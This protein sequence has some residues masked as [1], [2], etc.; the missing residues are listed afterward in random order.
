MKSFSLELLPHE[1]MY[2][3]MVRSR[4]SSAEP[5]TRT[6]LK[7]LVGNAH[8]Q[9]HSSFPC[10]I[11]HVAEESGR[12][13]TWLV[14]NHTIFPYFSSF[15]PPEIQ[16]QSRMGL[17]RGQVKELPSRL[18]L[19]ANRIYQPCILKYCPR[20][21]NNDLKSFGV[22]YWHVIHQ[23]PFIQFC[24]IHA[25]VLANE[26]VKRRT[27]ILPPQARCSKLNGPIASEKELL[28][29]SISQGLL[30]KGI[31]R[32]NLSRVTESYKAALQLSGF[33][34]PS[35]TIHQSDWAASLQTFWK[36]GLPSELSTS[37]F[38]DRAKLNFPRCVL[39]QP[40]ALHHPAKHILL[41]GQLFGSLNEFLRCYRDESFIF[42]QYVNDNLERK[43][44]VPNQKLRRLQKEL[45]QGKS[46]R[47]ASKNAQVSVGYAKSFALKNCFE[48][49]RRAQR[50]FAGERKLI[51][52]RLKE[53][54][55]TKGIA[56]EMQCSV[57]AVEQLLT[58]HPEIKQ[59]RVKLRFNNKRNKHRKAI[60]KFLDYSTAAKRND[61]KTS[62]GAAYTWCYKN[63]K[64]WLYKMLP[65]AIPREE[66]Y[67]GR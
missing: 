53:G 1:T 31:P 56:N 64:N 58:Q 36:Y 12:N 11:P 37:L 52:D 66:R 9:L 47:Q 65:E 39:Y 40:N 3:Y 15:L 32:F 49:D 57:G 8:C 6:C 42:T 33:C 27:L 4:F 62:C 46:L 48:I 35:G 43:P 20:C 44:R 63:D 18:S 61:I 50:L 21:V 5:S 60:L 51:L 54:V 29:T 41:I 19:I 26:P 13:V 10:Y 67:R 30:I 34:T 16:E 38:K 28:F 2:S 7:E 55:E 23:L 45:G 25:V 17:L 59:L 22:A 24:P 14:D